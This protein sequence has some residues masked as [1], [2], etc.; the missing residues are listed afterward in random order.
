MFLAILASVGLRMFEACSYCSHLYS[1]VKYLLRVTRKMGQWI[2]KGD[3]TSMLARKI[4]NTGTK[5]NIGKLPSL[6]MN[7]NIWWESLIERDF[8][9]LVEYDP[10]VVSYQ[11]QP[12]RINFTLQEKLRHYTP[13]FL[14]ERKHKR[15]V[16]EIKPKNKLAD[17]SHDL[18]FNSV[19]PICQEQGY[20]FLVVTDE[21]IRVE[22]RLTNIKILW[23]YARTPIY[24]VHQLYCQEFFR[25][26]KTPK[27]EELIS[28]FD[29]KGIEKDVV[30]NLIYSGII[31]TNLMLPLK[32][33][34]IVFFPCTIPES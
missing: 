6:K 27:L 32:A 26:M 15:Q 16:I 2:P 3:Q 22:P 8:L 29:S 13:D 31:S 7:R 34:S 33:E 19:A 10:D 4:K 9:Y 25:Q 30:Y 21:M 12:F 18:L 28:F 5:K 17:G 11:E 1:S 20:E 14:V 24:P 23:R